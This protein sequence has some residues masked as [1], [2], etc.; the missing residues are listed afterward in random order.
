MLVHQR[1][2]ELSSLAPEYEKNSVTRNIPYAGEV[3]RVDALLRSKYP[4]L[5][6][7]IFEI[8]SR[9]FVIVF[10]AESQCADAISHE[11]NNSIRFM[12]V[13]DTLSNTI[14]ESSLNEIPPLTDEDAIGNMT[15][16]PLSRIEL[17]NLLASRFP[18]AGILHLN[19]EPGSGQF[20]LS[21]QFV[22]DAATRAQIE[23]FVDS[24]Q[25]QLEFRIE[26]S[27]SPQ[28]PSP[29]EAHDP[30]FLWCARLQPTYPSYVRQDE[31]FWF[32]NIKN[33]SSNKL[34][35]NH[36]PGMKENVSRCYFDFSLA[37]R[38]V[39]LRQALLMYD[40]IWCSLPLSD[41][42]EEFFGIQ[43]LT[44]NDFLEMVSA[45]RVRV[46]T[47][48][49]EQRLDI[50]F[51]EELHECNPHSL[52][53]RRTTAAL[54]AADVVQM[55]ERSLLN[56][57][58][59]LP[60]IE[61]LARELGANSGFDP[62][63]VVRTLLWPFASRRDSLQGLLFRGS[64][65]GPVGSLALLLSD[66]IKE[67]SGVD[68]AL[69]TYVL[70]EPVHIGH[71]LNATVF[72]PIDERTVYY[73]LKSLLG[74]HL[75]MHRNFTPEAASSWIENELRKQNGTEL[76]PAIRMFEFDRRVP[77]REI[78][79]VTS[80]RS[81]QIRG[82]SLYTRLSE[83]NGAEREKEI[84]KLDTEMR[85]LSTRKSGWLIGLE[86]VDT[87]VSFASVTGGFYWLPFIGL[88]N[89]GTR[90]LEG[91][92]R[93][94]K[95]DDMMSNLEDRIVKDPQR[96]ELDFLSRIERVACLR[97]ERI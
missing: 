16:L 70:G 95:I 48:Q 83:L 8:K 92:R 35:P 18:D 52:Y 55:A 74:A 93:N 61:E 96:K 51:L 84:E 58:A 85:K 37:H 26:V 86:S 90:T 42:Q 80:I 59:L 47:T 31:T 63:Y 78:L 29:P 15:G 69:E 45:Q 30:L 57:P 21:V 89:L 6:T 43:A 64:K 62:N 22:L 46:V 36:F 66:G 60:G 87:V 32:D 14:P 5:S 56:D 4:N 17:L 72:G 75:N 67:M 49:P 73:R 97:R 54:L 23:E 91:L 13:P 38:H 44:K 7:R 94:K 9:H 27:N 53:G 3:R 1:P 76:L 81:T 79:K 19:D 88:Y 77:I 65:G 82:R 12:T 33:I 25:L 34:V 50:P 2:L 40:E 68:V 28:P 11:F 71:T 20:S 24:L 39:N 10:D 41:R